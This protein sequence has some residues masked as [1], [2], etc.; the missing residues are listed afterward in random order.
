MQSNAHNEKIFLLHRNGRLARIIWI[1]I[2][3]NERK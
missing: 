2:E 3:I 1:H